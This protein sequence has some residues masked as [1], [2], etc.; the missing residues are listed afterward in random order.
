M[1]LG[2]FEVAPERAAPAIA[3]TQS[4]EAPDSDHEVQPCQ[5][6][7]RRQ[8]VAALPTCTR[9]WRT[10]PR[11]S[12]TRPPSPRQWSMSLLL[13]H[14]GGGRF[15]ENKGPLKESPKWQ[16][17]H[18]VRTPIRYPLKLPGV[19]ARVYEGYLTG[20]LSISGSYYFGD[21][22]WGPQFS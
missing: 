14:M 3:T 6:R 5:P 21:P 18:I 2:H 13:H 17:S 9:R 16:D 1:G 10:H 20:V 4:L 19:G 12:L 11:Q 8:P 22:F 7:H 15:C